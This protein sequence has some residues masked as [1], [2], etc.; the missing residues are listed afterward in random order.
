MPITPNKMSS[1]SSDEK[2]PF[3]PYALCIHMQYMG[4]VARN[5]VFGGGGG[6]GGGG[7]NNKGKD[8]PALPHSLISAF[9]IRLLETNISRLTTSEISIF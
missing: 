1:F 8:Q 3:K 5:P 4:L 6:G 2:M 9:V 7:A